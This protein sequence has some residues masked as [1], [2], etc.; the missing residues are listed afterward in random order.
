[1]ATPITDAM[2]ASE[3]SSALY[4]LTSKNYRSRV[5]LF[6]LC[7]YMGTG[8]SIGV[9]VAGQTCGGSVLSFHYVAPGTEFVARLGSNCPNRL[10]HFTSPTGL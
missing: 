5:D 9:E 10:S 3:C 2:G 1:M 7:V 6:G 8:C 4:L